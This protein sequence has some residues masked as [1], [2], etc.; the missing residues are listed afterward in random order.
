MPPGSVLHKVRTA[1]GRGIGLR[2][3]PPP[4]PRGFRQMWR[5]SDATPSAPRDGGGDAAG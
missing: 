4:A 2:H 5:E 3:L 1:L